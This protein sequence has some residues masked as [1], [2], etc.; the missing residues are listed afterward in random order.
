MPDGLG[1][2]GVERRVVATGEETGEQGDPS[3]VG[4]LVSDLSDDRAYLRGKVPQNPQALRRAGCDQDLV[5]AF[6]GVECLREC[7]RELLAAPG[8][9]EPRPFARHL[10]H[11]YALAS[12]DDDVPGAFRSHLAGELERHDESELNHESRGKHGQGDRHGS[13]SRCRRRRDHYEHDACLLLESSDEVCRSRQ[14]VV[15]AGHLARR[16][17]ALPMLPGARSD[18]ARVRHA[19]PHRRT[20]LLAALCEPLDLFDAAGAAGVPPQCVEAARDQ[21]RRSE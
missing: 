20:R 3:H 2:A 10:R 21:H 16:S 5:P 13:S 15:G 18:T 6:C 17:E 14:R 1:V 19:R 9:G 4:V 7:V 11:V 8:V 12:G